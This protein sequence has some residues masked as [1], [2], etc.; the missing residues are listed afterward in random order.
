MA[1]LTK[2]QSGPGIG[3]LTGAPVLLKQ[4]FMQQKRLMGFKKRY[5]RLLQ[6]SLFSFA[7]ADTKVRLVSVGE[8]HCAALR[9]SE[10]PHLCTAAVDTWLKPRVVSQTP[11]DEIA[12]DDGSVEDVSW[13]TKTG[14]ALRITTSDGKRHLFICTNAAEHRQWFDALYYATTLSL[15]AE[16]CSPLSGGWLA[17]LEKGVFVKRWFVV[18]DAFLLCY[19]AREDMN[20][21]RDG[22][23]TGRRFVLPLT[24]AMLS[25][26]KTSMAAYTFSIQ[27]LQM[28]E[29]KAEF[30]FAAASE[31]VMK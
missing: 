13:E 10:G 18:K 9:S 19:D 1:E 26:Y 15:L 4:G 17:Q 24:G 5:F 29:V 21:R 11:L 27:M 8:E 2:K 6:D 30:V 12:L 3:S 22:Q 31:A 20:N 28:G 16:Y 14:N 25:Y 23:M 7:A